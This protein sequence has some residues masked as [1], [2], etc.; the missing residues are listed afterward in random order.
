[1]TFKGTLVC[2]V[3]AASLFALAAPASASGWAQSADDEKAKAASLFLDPQNA[4]PM[5]Q[6]KAPAA[7]SG[8]GGAMLEGGR[9]TEAEPSEFD[10]QKNPRVWEIAKQLRCLVCANENIAES[11]ADLA[12]DLR[13][14]VAQQVEEN[15]T[16]DEIIGFM[17]ERYGEYV[18]YKPPFKMKT[19]FLW[20]GPG[21]F[22]L[23]A[24]WA[25]VRISR[26]RRSL[27]ERRRRGL[28]PEELERALSILKGAP[29]T[30]A[31]ESK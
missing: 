18:L 2:L 19:A 12:V 11:N 6:T 24:L 27:S 26:S 20:L 13:R 1:M 10:P 14:V 31:G 25:A 17:V 23:L 21:A 7:A 4:A 15:R 16:D 8:E 5:P 28:S 9:L 22:F 29:L 3:A 30:G